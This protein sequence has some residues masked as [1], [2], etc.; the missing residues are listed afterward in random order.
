MESSASALRYD[1]DAPHEAQSE[2]TKSFCY[3]ECFLS[4]K[5]TDP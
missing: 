1:A 4:L 3:F 5:V 2:K